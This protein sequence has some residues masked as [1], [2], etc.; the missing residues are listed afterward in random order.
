MIDSR[1]AVR[2]PSVHDEIRAVHERPGANAN[3]FTRTVYSLRWDVLKSS[4]KIY[5]FPLAASVTGKLSW[6]AAAAGRE[7]AK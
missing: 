2:V 3:V 1:G 6:L 4:K 5:K 7:E